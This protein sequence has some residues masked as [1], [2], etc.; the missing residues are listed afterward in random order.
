[1]LTVKI[2]SRSLLQISIIIIIV[3]SFTIPVSGGAWTEKKGGGFYKLSFRYLNADAI[4]NSSGDKIHSPDFT[5]VTFG[6]YGSYGLTDKVSLL[7]NA[8]L[9]KSVKLGKNYSTFQTLVEDREESGFGDISLGLKYAFAKID[10]TVFSTSLKLGLP[11][12]ESSVDGDLWTGHKDFNQTISIEAGHSFYPFRMYVSG[13]IAFTNRNEGFSDEFRYLIECGYNLGSGFS[14]IG[15]FHGLV[16]MKNG[17][18]NLIGGYGI[19][20][21]NAQYFAYNAELVYKINSI[22]G[23]SINFESGGGGKNIISAPVFSAGVFYTM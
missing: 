5:D 19:F 18:E 7:M 9:F 14:L 21:N 22:V 1:M 6:F 2:L 23:A 10:Q 8:A 3:I 13:L 12:G 17:N 4:Y 11:T 15:R 20:M 16:S